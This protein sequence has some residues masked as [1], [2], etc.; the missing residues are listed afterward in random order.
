MDK[1]LQKGAVDLAT[2][3][4]QFNFPKLRL[5]PLVSTRFA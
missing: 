2:Y 3:Q 1:K 5:L 4:D